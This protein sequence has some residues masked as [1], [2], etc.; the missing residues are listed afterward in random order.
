MIQRRT[1]AF[2]LIGGG[3]LALLAVVLWLMW[4]WL[5]RPAPVKMVTPIATAPAPYHP[6][7]T[8]PKLHP[9]TKP[10]SVTPET[11]S[12]QSAEDS[13]KRQSVAWVERAGTFSSVDGFSSLNQVFVESVPSIQQYL[14]S[15]QQALVKAHPSVGATYGQ[16]TRAFSASI[17]D[18]LPLLQHGQAR[19][20]VQAQQTTVTDAT[21]TKEYVQTELQYDQ[22]G[23]SWV[24]THVSTEPLKL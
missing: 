11:T 22:Q 5:H 23:A 15:Q 2:L 4:P 12:E 6:S 3:F 14:Q 8:A 9:I 19:V 17:V 1:V 21:S 13:L 24:V 10:T 18:G 16:T 20:L 7:F